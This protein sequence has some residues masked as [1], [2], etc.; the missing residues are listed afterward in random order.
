MKQVKE[1]LVGFLIGIGIYTAF[2]ELFGVFF[3]GNALY[4][5]LGLLTGAFV[6]VALIIHMAVTLNKALDLPQD[7]AASYVR[8][9]SFLRL[10]VMLAAL[11]LGLIF[12]ELNF[13]ALVLGL[14]GL[15]IGALI[16]PFFLKCLYPDDFLTKEEE[17]ETLVC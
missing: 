13:I 17:E 8:R 4:Y 5:T 6:S 7:K 14:L 1:T 15:K 2:V 3:S 9:Q 10:A 11:V 12:D 16:A